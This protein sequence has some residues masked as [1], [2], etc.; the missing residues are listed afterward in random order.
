MINQALLET[1]MSTPLLKSTNRDLPKAV[2]RGSDNN[3]D[4]NTKR[5]SNAIDRT[6]ISNETAPKSHITSRLL[7]ERSS[8]PLTE[9]KDNRNNQC[10]TSSKHRSQ[11]TLSGE[12]HCHH[13]FSHINTNKVVLLS[14]SDV[15]DTPPPESHLTSLTEH[16]LVDAEKAQDTNEQLQ[17]EQPSNKDPSTSQT[18][19]DGK[20]R[21]SIEEILLANSSTS[22]L[23]EEGDQLV[24]EK[25]ENA[26]SFD[27][28]KV[29]QP[30]KVPQ[31]LKRELQNMQLRRSPYSAP[32]LGKFLKESDDN[33][34]QLDASEKSWNEIHLI[35]ASESGTITLTSRDGLGKQY[36]MPAI[37][38]SEVEL[39]SP[40]SLQMN[41]HE[42][43][44]YSIEERD[45]CCSIKHSISNYTYL[46]NER[47]CCT[48][49]NRVYQEHQ[50]HQHRHHHQK[51][52]TNGC[53]RKHECCSSK[54]HRN[55]ACQHCS[56]SASFNHCSDS[57]KKS[58]SVYSMDASLRTSSM[59]Q[60]NTRHCHHNSK[61]QQK[62]DHQHSH[63]CHKHRD[64]SRSRYTL[65]LEDG[66]L[67]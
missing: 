63:R 14:S 62:H 56:S 59:H 49:D 4:K 34:Q 31:K 22:T 5:M 19:E 26:S 16:L 36:Q 8:S 25:E 60:K 23:T 17:E 2:I 38:A 7:Y 33:E 12:H 28:S 67:L 35:T 37:I 53:T 3:S 46:A 41:T 30:I 10:N 58:F 1:S 42:K 21:R 20:E 61:K 43:E 52:S 11:C 55:N 48:L 54:N 45:Q 15:P 47:S 44:G 66:I 64:S 18:K 9:G 39:K 40:I 51:R 24:N 57:I 29:S 27:I 65:V 50:H 32:D 13:R 6:E